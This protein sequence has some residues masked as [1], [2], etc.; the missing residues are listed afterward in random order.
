LGSVVRIEDVAEVDEEVLEARAFRLAVAEDVE[1]ERACLFA[2]G[3][4]CEIA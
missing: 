2:G 3:G 1:E 4:A